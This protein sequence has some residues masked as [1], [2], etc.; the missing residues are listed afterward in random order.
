MRDIS[1]EAIDAMVAL[2]HDMSGS[3]RGSRGLI[4]IDEA[5]RIAAL[6]PKPVDPDLVYARQIVSQRYD[7][8]T[9]N[10]DTVADILAT[11]KAIRR[12]GLPTTN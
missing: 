12:D 10:D 2:V 8:E 5:I 1:D 6:L 9:P 7:T 11:I 4:W 3:R